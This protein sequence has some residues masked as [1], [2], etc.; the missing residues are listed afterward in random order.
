MRLK[1]CRDFVV[2][3]PIKEPRLI[4]LSKD[5]SKYRRGRVLAV[6]PGKRNKKGNR[7]PID[8][9]VGEL[10]VFKKHTAKMFYVEQSL[11][12]FVENGNILGVIEEASADETRKAQK[13]SL[14]THGSETDDRYQQEDTARPR[15]RRG[16]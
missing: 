3:E 9:Q 14:F 2:L 15:I 1:P 13:N 5:K 10:V 11:V 16:V 12:A 7:I 4:L 6:G 8:V